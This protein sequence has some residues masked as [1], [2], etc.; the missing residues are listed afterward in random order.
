MF[1]STLRH[2]SLRAAGTRTAATVAGNA[3]KQSTSSS[4][5]QPVLVAAGLTLAATT[6]AQ[7]EKVRYVCLCLCLWEFSYL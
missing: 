4:Y 6:F 5:Y 3:S 2:A 1:A 7:V